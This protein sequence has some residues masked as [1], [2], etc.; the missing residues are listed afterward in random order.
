MQARQSENVHIVPLSSEGKKLIVSQIS[1]V[2]HPMQAISRLFC[3]NGNAYSTRLWLPVSA[4][5]RQNLHSG[6][7]WL[8]TP[9]TTQ[10]MNSTAS[11]TEITIRNSAGISF[12]H[13]IYV[14]RYPINTNGGD[15]N[16]K[17]PLWYR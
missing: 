6:Q 7:R 10:T 14:H 13:W 2:L 16:K 9:D 17:T 5:N 3:E 4:C 11:E 8:A 15:R 12:G 1:F